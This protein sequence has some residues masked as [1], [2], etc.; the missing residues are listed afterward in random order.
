MACTLSPRMNRPRFFAS[1][2]SAGSRGLQPPILGIDRSR[3]LFI[4]D[5]PEVLNTGKVLSCPTMHDYMAKSNPV[6]RCIDNPPTSPSDCKARKR[7]LDELM[8]Q[9]PMRQPKMATPNTVRRCRRFKHTTSTSHSA[10]TVSV[11]RNSNNISA[12]RVKH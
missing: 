4:D 10:T 1:P 7:R 11:V 9:K 6:T 12:Q 5:S 2:N 3:P 8:E